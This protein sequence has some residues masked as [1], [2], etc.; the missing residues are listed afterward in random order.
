M[1]VCTLVSSTLVTRQSLCRVRALNVY[2][3]LRLSSVCAVPELG[4][5]DREVTKV[6]GTQI[7][8][9]GI[10]LQWDEGKTAGARRPLAA[11]RKAI[12]GGA[13]EGHVQ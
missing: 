2:R 10:T 9:V 13:G 5:G 11:Q 4:A 3:L 7:W 6:G 8:N 12:C 1:H